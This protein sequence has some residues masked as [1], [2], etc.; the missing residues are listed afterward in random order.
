MLMEAALALSLLL[1]DSKLLTEDP[2]LLALEG[3]ELNLLP[4]VPEK[5]TGEEITPV[6]HVIQDNTSVIL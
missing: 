5:H 2:E 6:P 3:L 1:T 4:A